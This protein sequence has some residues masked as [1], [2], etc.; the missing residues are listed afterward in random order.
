MN[1]RNATDAICA[2]AYVPITAACDSARS[3][4]LLYRPLVRFVDMA[5]TR[6]LTQMQLVQH[7]RVL[8]SVH[9]HACA[10][11]ALLPTTEHTR[12][13]LVEVRALPHSPCCICLDVVTGEIRSCRMCTALPFLES[14]GSRARLGLPT[15]EHRKQCELLYSRPAIY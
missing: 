13:A 14:R 11:T 15:V 3:M 9:G 1:A 10:W 4:S 2:L 7:A 5:S 8:A 6:L 12:C